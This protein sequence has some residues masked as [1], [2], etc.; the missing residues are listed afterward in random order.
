[1]RAALPDVP[2]ETFDAALTRLAD[3][4]DVHVNPSGLVSH[5]D[6]TEEDRDASLWMGNQHHHQISIDDRRTATGIVGRLHM[7]DRDQAASMV[8]ALN[9]REVESVARRMG[10]DVFPGEPTVTRQRLIDQSVANHDAWLADAKQGEEDGKL[11]YRA[12]SDPDWV[13]SWTDDDRQRAA[14]AA[15]R[16]QERAETD[17][18][19][20]YVRE[21]ADR[22]AQR[23]TDS[24]G[25]TQPAPPDDSNQQDAPVSDTTQAA[26]PE[27]GA[28]GM[29]PEQAAEAAQ[30]ATQGA[31]GSE[32]SQPHPVSEANAGSHTAQAAASD[33]GTGAGEA[34]AAAR[35][36]DMDEVETATGGDVHSAEQNK[37]EADTAVAEYA[38]ELQ[39]AQCDAARARDDLAAGE[40][41]AAAMVAATAPE[42]KVGLVAAL[43]DPLKARL[44]SA[45]ARVNAASANLANVQAVQAAAAADA[46]LMG[47]AVGPWYGN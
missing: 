38:A 46:A 21:R 41:W 16:L 8:A 12:D 33:P 11:L 45:E 2:R 30:Q 24:D 3:H 23:P 17:P 26:Q 19:W 7:R 10:V 25:P 37:A 31:Q 13:A 42:A 40:D 6:M 4:S 15:A 29:T 14:E 5:E 20:A 28:G 44:A 18:S 47:R 39:D 43:V 34:G 1:V 22:W 9:D 35:H 27:T 32:A 36:A